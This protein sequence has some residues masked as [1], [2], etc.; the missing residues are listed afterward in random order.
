MFRLDALVLLSGGRGVETLDKLSTKVVKNENLSSF[1]SDSTTEIL[2]SN[3][4]IG[5][6]SKGEVVA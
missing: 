6:T 2:R 4:C 3:F 5:N 1:Q